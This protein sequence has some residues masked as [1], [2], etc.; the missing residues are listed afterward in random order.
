MNTTRG[1][2]LGRTLVT[3]GAQALEGT[4][5]RKHIARHRP[6]GPDYQSGETHGR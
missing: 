4:R 3:L 6:R 5:L 2:P 1:P